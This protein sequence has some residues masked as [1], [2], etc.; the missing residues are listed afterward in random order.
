VFAGRKVRD[1]MADNGSLASLHT[2]L[3]DASNGYDEAIRDADQPELKAIFGRLKLAHE[4]AHAELHHLLLARGLKPDDGGS[5]MSTV[6]KTIISV[7]SAV[8]GLNDEALSAFAEGEERIVEDYNRAIEGN[9]D[10]AAVV[11]LLERQKE[12]LKDEIRVMR[13][14]ADGKLG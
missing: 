6:H 14:T 7:R 2:A 13:A 1:S 8:T 10:D 3:I 5:F 9:R 11:G 12:A 4:K